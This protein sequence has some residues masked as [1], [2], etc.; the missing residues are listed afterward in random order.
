MFSLDLSCLH[1]FP[2]WE[3][4]CTSP[5]R[6]ALQHCAGLWPC[7]VG[8]SDSNLVLLLL[9]LP[10][11]STAARAGVFSS[12]GGFSVLSCVQRHRVCSLIE[13]IQSAACVAGGKFWVPLRSCTAPG[14][15]L[16]LCLHLCLCVLHGALLLRL[17]WRAWACPR[18]DG[19]QGCSCWG[20]RAWGTRCSGELAPR[21]EERAF[22]S[23]WQ[24]GPSGDPAWGWHSCLHRG[25]SGGTECAGTP[26]VS[27]E[28]ALVLPGSRPGLWQLLSERLCGCSF[29]TAPGSLPREGSNRPASLWG[30]P[31]S[32]ADVWGQRGYSNGSTACM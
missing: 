8:S 19:V 5:R 2:C 30:L 24:L 10:P 21:A 26:A 17:P 22:S 32:R 31:L 6:D 1:P 11:R 4:P 3:F 28:G 12:A 29:S 20:G 18:E 7:C 16:W 15:P 25:N 27:A 23:L 9:F 14:F 13:W